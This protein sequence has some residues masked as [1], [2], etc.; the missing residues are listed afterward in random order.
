MNWYICITTLLTTWLVSSF[1]MTVTWP[2]PL[3]HAWSHD[4]H[5][6][7]PS[8][9]C[10]IKWQSHDPS[11]FCM[12]DHMTVAWP[13]PLLHAWSNDSHMNP[14][15]PLRTTSTN[16]SSVWPRS[17][18]TLQTK[19]TRMS[20]KTVHVYISMYYASK[21]YHR[22]SPKSYHLEVHILDCSLWSSMCCIHHCE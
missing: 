15:F 4:S 6:T 9:A 20:S 10:L 5:M 17:G 14:F 1:H 8:S 2:L 3:L 16:W 18:R 19:Q 13:L 12:P 7:P 21:P 22:I 11:L